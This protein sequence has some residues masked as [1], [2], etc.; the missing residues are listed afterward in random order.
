MFPYFSS[1]YASEC[2]CSD[3]YFQH[4]L[5]EIPTDHP[6]LVGVYTNIKLRPV[7]DAYMQ[8][9]I[10]LYCNLNGMAEFRVLQ[11]RRQKQ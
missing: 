8:R 9:N 4:R 5:W 2:S 1:M 7:N 6:I 10:I 11:M 3:I